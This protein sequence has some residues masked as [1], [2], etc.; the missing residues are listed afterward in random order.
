[1]PEASYDV[2][3]LWDVIEHVTD[4]LAEIQRAHRLLKPGGLLAAHTMDIDSLFARLMG[5]RW[6]WLMEMHIYFFSRR[7]LT[8]LLE[9]AGFKVIRA[10]PQGRYLRLGY[11]ATRVGGLLGQPA[12]RALGGLFKLLRLSQAPIPINL[13][14][15]FT[16]YAVKC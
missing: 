11:F 8:A 12:G 15:L 5:A 6:P 10:A 14:D 13:G 2:L 16:A 4:P 3:T 1:L 7:T 9:K